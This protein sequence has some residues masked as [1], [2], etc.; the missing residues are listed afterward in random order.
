MSYLVAFLGN[1]GTQY[2][3]TRHNAAWRL[4]FELERRWYP[5][6]QRKFNGRYAQ[7]DLS[8]PPG[9]SAGGGSPHGGRATRAV[10]LVPETFMNKSGESVQPCARFFRFEPPSIVVVHD[11]TEID[12]GFIGLKFGGGLGGNNGLKST[13]ER[14][15]TRDFYRLRIGISR[16]RRGSLSS[17]VLG[18]FTP[19]EES[20]LPTVLEEAARLLETALTTELKP[21]EPYRALGS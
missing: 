4:L 2:E 3:R 11:D 14:L 8:P 20:E 1:P 7:V 6:W 16:P 13:A 15:G 10:L 21:T 18:K 19:E 17:H 9:A 12:F 5:S